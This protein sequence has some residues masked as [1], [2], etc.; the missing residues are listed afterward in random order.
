MRVVSCYKYG[1]L[2]FDKTMENYL[3]DLTDLTLTEEFFSTYLSIPIFIINAASFVETI[4]NSTL[5]KPGPSVAS[6]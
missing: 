2:Y 3:Q 5:F 1:D 6:T 4:S